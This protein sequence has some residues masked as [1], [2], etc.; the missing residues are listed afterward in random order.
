MRYSG[1]TGAC[2]NC[3]TF[4]NLVGQ[5]VQGVPFQDRIQRYS[6][7]TTWSNGE[8]VQRGTGGNYG[9][10]AFLR[11]GFTYRK[12]VDYLYGRVLEHYEIGADTDS[13]LS[14]DWKIKLAAS[15]VPRGLEI[16]GIFY[17]LLIAQLEKCLRSKLEDEIKLSIGQP[18]LPSSLVIAVS[19]KMDEIAKYLKRSPD[20]VDS[21]RESP[22]VSEVH[23]RVLEKT[24][25]L[26]KSVANALKQTIDFSVEL[27]QGNQR[28]SS[29]LYNQPKPVDSV[30]DD[31]AVEAQNFANSLT[32][33]ASYAAATIA[34]NSVD[35]TGFNIAS[36]AFA[37]WNISLSFST[38][39][40]VSRYGN[41]NEEA[42][43]KF[44]DEKM[45]I[46]MKSVFSLMT[47]S[48]REDIVLENNP[49]V[50]H[51]DSLV[52]VFVH[53]A[54][55]YNIAEVK[56]ESFK[57]AYDRFRSSNLDQ[58]STVAFARQL[59]QEFIP[60]TFHENSYLQEH[61]VNIYKALDEMLTL[62]KQA[63]SNGRTG[64]DELYRML[65]A[66]RPKL[67]A[68]IERGG[69]RYGF[70]RDHAW[71]RTPLPVTLQYIFSPLLGKLTIA[72]RTLSIL[73]AAEAMRAPDGIDKT[74][75]K[76]IQDLTELYHATNESAISNMIFVSGFSVFCFSIFFTI[77]RFI[78][79]GSTA[80]WVHLVLRYTP[81]ASIPSTL[82][83]TIA[84]THF[85][86]KLRILFKLDV[87]LGRSNMKRDPRI[88]RIRFTTRIQE[89]LV[90]VRLIVVC[91][92]SVALPWGVANS[93]FPHQ[94]IHPRKG[95]FSYPFYVAV[96][97]A[98]SAVTAAIFFFF[99]EF[100]VRYNLDPRLGLAVSCGCSVIWSH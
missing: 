22:G 47:R 95:R 29:E 57:Q 86:R 25:F 33:S 12:L 20:V 92:A 5:A 49:F 88:K 69:I 23:D 87:A 19:H 31:F 32:E 16:D 93:T 4:N 80:P 55:Y 71:Y 81:W 97:A 17:E 41:R 99:V 61:L 43:R 89:L 65:L 74:L 72:T 94:V 85:V 35:A 53:Y 68:S 38:M 75:G 37:I 48:Q 63:P 18:E 83:S 59:L 2:I 56:I 70:V 11:P 44:F 50:I 98:V 9:E 79:Y 27:R 39:T 26:M 54:R 45:I 90:A 13:V 82:G 1:L 15:V 73:K 58:M 36:A 100:V 3:V 64:A 78:G 8:V 96:A 84:I 67:A 24:G 76:P 66:F 30:V 60:D 14:R 42:R 51:L 40:N 34:F 28:L 7:E 77:F 46:V 52:A 21:K 6:F 91:A 10:D 62:A